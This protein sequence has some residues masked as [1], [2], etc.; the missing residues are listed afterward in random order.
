MDT[1]IAPGPPHRKFHKDG[2]MNDLQIYVQDIPVLPIFPESS[3]LL[4][5]SLSSS[6]Q[7]YKKVTK[8][9]TATVIT[10]LPSSSNI[11][12]SSNRK[13]EYPTMIHTSTTSSSSSLQQPLDPLPV[14]SSSSSRGTSS[15]SVVHPLPPPPSLST[16]NQPYSPPPLP[17]NL[18]TESI[19]KEQNLWIEIDDIVALIQKYQSGL[20]TTQP[21]SGGNNTINT[22]SVVSS[23]SYEHSRQ[24]FFHIL[25]ERFN[26]IKES[27]LILEN[28]HQTEK[29]Q[30]K[31]TLKK[32]EDQLVT[33]KE[34]ISSAWTEKWMNR[35]KY[36][37]SIVTNLRTTLQ[38]Y[39]EQNSLPHNN[40]PLLS[41]SSRTVSPSIGNGSSSLV[42]HHKELSQPIRL[43]PFEPS[44][45]SSISSSSSPA[46]SLPSSLS[47]SLNFLALP[48]FN[49]PSSIQP[50][51]FLQRSDPLSGSTTTGTLLSIPTSSGGNT[52]NTTTVST[53][54]LE[55]LMTTLQSSLALTK[56][57]RAE[58]SEAIQQ[59]TDYSHQI[60]QYETDTHRYQQTIEQLRQHIV[61]LQDEV[62][63]T[64]KQKDMMELESEAAKI[65]A[66]GMKDMME[67]LNREAEE[68]RH[69]L[70][71]EQD[72][73]TQILAQNA[74]VRQEADIS[75]IAL[76]QLRG[77]VVRS[78]RYMEGYLHQLMNPQDTDEDET[79]KSETNNDAMVLPTIETV[80]PQI[81]R[82]RTKQ[83]IDKFTERIKEDTTKYQLLTRDYQQFQREA[84]SE[85]RRLRALYEASTGTTIPSLLT[86]L[87]GNTVKDSI[88]N[89]ALAQT[90]GKGLPLSSTS[91]AL[92]ANTVKP[93][94]TFTTNNNNP[95]TTKPSTTGSVLPSSSSSN[96][97]TAS[98]LRLTGVPRETIQ[99]LTNDTYTSTMD[100]YTDTY[101]QQQNNLTQTMDVTIEEYDILQKHALD[102][103]I[104]IAELRTALVIAEEKVTKLSKRLDQTLTDLRTVGNA[105]G[106]NIDKLLLA[107]EQTESTTGGGPPST[108][109]SSIITP[110]PQRTALTMSSLSGSTIP[111]QLTFEN[112]FITPAQ[113]ALLVATV[114]AD[115][116]ECVLKDVA[117]AATNAVN[118]G[119]LSTA[120][121]RLT[122]LGAA[123][124]ASEREVKRL[125]QILDDL[126]TEW[127][128]KQAD[129]EKERTLVQE[130][131]RILKEESEKMICQREE[132]MAFQYVADK[133]R[134][135]AEEEIERMK[136]EHKD[137]LKDKQH[138]Y[139]LLEE[140][141]AVT[142]TKFVQATEETQSLQAAIRALEVDYAQQL[143]D[144][145]KTVRQETEKVCELRY[146]EELRTIGNKVQR[147]AEADY[148]VQLQQR[149]IEQKD[150]LRIQFQEELNLFRQ[151][152]E[153][154]LETERKI[155]EM[156][157]R[158]AVQTAIA[159]TEEKE[160]TIAADAREEL[161]DQHAN[162]IQRIRTQTEEFIIGIENDTQERIHVIEQSLELTKESA[163]TYGKLLLQQIRYY[164][165]LVR[166][167][168]Q[169]RRHLH[170][171]ILDLQGNIRVHVRIR[172]NKEQIEQM[173]TAEKEGH[174]TEDMIMKNL[175]VTLPSVS[176]SGDL[177]GNENNTE[178]NIPS[179]AMTSTV[180]DVNDQSDLPYYANNNI[181]HHQITTECVKALPEGQLVV[182]APYGSSLGT[183]GQPVIPTSLFPPM[184]VPNSGNDSP[185]ST[186]EADTTIAGAAA[187]V[188]QQQGSKHGS[189]GIIPS[190]VYTTGGNPGY[191]GNNTL[192][193]T[194]NG[195]MKPSN[196]QTIFE[197]EFDEVHGPY[198]TQE[199]IFDYIRP[200]MHN[201]LQGINSCI[202]AYGATGSGKTFTME[203][204]YTTMTAGV[205]SLS[206]TTLSDASHMGV[207]L[208]SMKY[209]FR[210]AEDKC[211]HLGIDNMF[212]PNG[213][214][215]SVSIMEIYQE[216]VRDLLYGIEG[217][218][219]DGTVTTSVSGPDQQHMKT[220]LQQ[221]HN[222]GAGKNSDSY[223]KH[224]LRHN[225]QDD[226]H[227]NSLYSADNLQVRETKDGVE[228]VNLTR[229]PL[230][231]MEQTIALLSKGS[232]RRHK[233]HHLLNEHSSRSH[234]IVRLWIEGP[235]N[236][237]VTTGTTATMTT[238]VSTPN[239]RSISSGFSSFVPDKRMM[240][241]LH[242]VDLA[243]S[244]RI[245][246]TGT[247]GHQLKE[248]SYINTSLTAL[249][250]CI[251]NLRKQAPHIPY[252]DS[253]LTFVLK[254]SMG[255]TSKLLMF[256]CI[257]ND[258][259]DLSESI[260]TL[261]F[262]SRCRST[263]LGAA[264]KNIV[265]K[266]TVPVVV[267]AT[268]TSPPALERDTTD[269]SQGPSINDVIHPLRSS[270]IDNP[271]SSKDDYRSHG[272]VSMEMDSSSS[273]SSAKKGSASK[274]T[275]HRSTSGTM[276]TKS[277]GKMDSIAPKE[278][279]HLNTLTSRYDDISGNNSIYN[280]DRLPRIPMDSIGKSS[281][282]NFTDRQGND[283]IRST[284]DHKIFTTESEVPPTMDQLEEVHFT[285]YQAAKNT[286]TAKANTESGKQVRFDDTNTYPEVEELPQRYRAALESIFPGTSPSS[287]LV[288]YEDS[289]RSRTVAS[290]TTDNFDNQVPDNATVT[291]TTDTISVEE[292]NYVPMGGTFKGG[293]RIS[294]SSMNNNDGTGGVPSST[295]TVP[296]PLPSATQA[297]QL[298]FLKKKISSSSSTTKN[299][300]SGTTN[301]VTSGTLPSLGTTYTAGTLTKALKLETNDNNSTAKFTN[302]L[303]YS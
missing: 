247:E 121:D 226:R 239:G 287:Y 11:I 131:K 108:T 116:R 274:S 3:S 39:E 242:F 254:D 101:T 207:T 99:L 155:M 55:T 130:Q 106:I 13:D 183:D 259:Q 134:K 162:E 114:R 63:Q 191:H 148:S 20:M 290:T 293:M 227:S 21:P 244:E 87:H 262:A 264:P 127:R 91:T 277:T 145:S 7:E 74:Q 249:G 299:N 66:E 231:S 266:P 268:I 136:Q 270:T 228:V 9:P 17:V 48:S 151:E 85:I 37:R 8:P 110:L 256:A 97:L 33:Y 31:E 123:A 129:M 149:L 51:G 166:K 83:L 272:F 271:L 279:I 137:T 189:Y 177:E 56:T 80:T 180:M 251:S 184:F 109:G 102:S 210:L 140:A 196:R 169:R 146:E 73:E 238:T 112:T 82:D 257:S 34:D 150:N 42:M 122:A 174:R 222:V 2:T 168:I 139:R 118:Q 212:H 250:Q 176:S 267:T 167:E 158:E 77:E 252:R 50:Q 286:L 275:V 297:S 294:V 141:L 288:K 248:A 303:S 143:R 69:Q 152:Q 62:D 208:R 103:E 27:I 245:F 273:S 161:M 111:N 181:R 46:S 147:E 278:L 107:Y 67:R 302:K 213:Y 260:S 65:T 157:K 216:K 269:V 128:T 24:R 237:V 120:A 68:Q 233:G 291:K 94:S 61:K 225:E 28:Q 300:R 284:M 154:G 263:P 25:L 223:W 10:T 185:G 261:N 295:I 243:G 234:M 283:R 163:V 60:A 153:Q 220:L 192:T 235:A 204:P 53:I 199:T 19:T 202:F 171:K 45:S 44:S 71:Q 93:T 138:Q 32:Y 76:L 296:P 292:D 117:T 49:D 236:N 281:M 98:I 301:V 164:K 229:I 240:A 12:R 179:Y 90:D 89:R 156:E 126:S 57:L 209:L 96:S 201:A 132:Y 219:P 15:T 230:V 16:T 58:N 160:R 52:T 221:Q 255:G 47:S 186:E 206:H 30:Y 23:S 64:R 81:I 78:I 14:T 218:S 5:S 79:L 29:Q 26:Q 215:F 232:E 54:D 18:F 144:T 38:T 115:E 113:L 84:V 104:R 193:T 258:E 289:R 190:S 175:G 6:N 217:S 133:A 173:V 70:K 75:S 119:K 187:T 159:S 125:V 253:K 4:F 285:K 124:A 265:V 170:G 59:V 211:E 100:T 41:S 95:T 88:L 182:Y 1:I 43:P 105:G 178:E 35:E 135:H 282:D 92:A 22:T 203:G 298:L 200:L 86:H 195:T 280:D 241:V 194:N 205:S 172:P 198:S 214:Q 36:W 197:Y 276:N 246:R 40:Q 165:Q 142:Q 224:E 72:A 188:V